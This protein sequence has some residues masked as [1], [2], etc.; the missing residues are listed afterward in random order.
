MSENENKNCAA[1]NLNPAPAENGADKAPAKKSW[2]KKIA[3]IA[4]TVL[5]VLVVLVLL[6]LWQIDRVA[7]TATRTVG[8]AITGTKVDVESI[9]IRP[10]AGAVKIKGFTVGNAEGFHNPTAIKVGNLH[11]ALNIS[12]VLTDKI[13]VDHLEIS[14]VAIDM[15]YGISKGSNLD[16]LLKNVEKN[17]GAD[18]KKAQAAKEEKKAEEKP[19]A[20]KQVVIRKLILKDSKVTVS[21]GLLKT[22]M[23]IP[24]VPISM[25]NVGE[26]TDMAGA[27]QEVLVRIMAEIAN[28][29]NFDAIGKGIVSGADAVGKG[30]NAVGKGVVSG[31]DAVGKGIVS[32]ADAV[33]KGITSGVEGAGK[34]VDGAVEGTVKFLKKLPGLGE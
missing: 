27:I 32:G 12:S 17:T 9:S 10:L 34:A 15:E 22:T 4:L 26:K 11:V 16:A 20:Q 24:L 28:V 21:S 13:V 29:V 31:A 33:G 30:A 14:D 3:K 25:E 7:A 6:L 18:K 23:S 8:S 2:G 1:E 5:I 19:A